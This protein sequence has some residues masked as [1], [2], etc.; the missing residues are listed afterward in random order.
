MRRA[1]AAQRRLLALK[2]ATAK[3]EA[4]MPLSETET[5]AI[6]TAFKSARKAAAVRKRPRG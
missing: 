4:L 2:Q 3:L 6:T 5:D 1:S